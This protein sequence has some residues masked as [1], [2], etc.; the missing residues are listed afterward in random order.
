MIKH[1]Q[2]Y[3]KLLS[4][5]KKIPIE[6]SEQALLIS[7]RLERLEHLTNYSHIYFSD[8]TDEKKSKIKLK[9]YLKAIGALKIHIIDLSLS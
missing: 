9:V 6:K 7:R 3:D 8:I 2:M 4:K 1:K 5:I